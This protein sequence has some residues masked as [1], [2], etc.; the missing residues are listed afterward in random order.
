MHKTVLW[1][2]F[3]ATT[4]G[5]YAADLPS[6]APTAAQTAT[7]T[8]PEAEVQADAKNP[9]EAALVSRP[10][11]ARK[12]LLVGDSTTQVL[13]GWGGS[14]CA[15]HVSAFLAC[16]DLARGGR[17]TR[18]FRVEGSWDMAMKEMTV[19]GY[20][21]VYVLIQ[22]GHNDQHGRPGRSTDL[23]T[24]FPGNLRRYVEDARS[25]GAVPVLVTP[26]VR[27][28]FKDGK[29]NND[30]ADWSDAVRKVAADLKVPLV[31]LNA[32]SAEAV[33]AMGAAVATRLAPQAPSAAI[34]TAAE[35]G[36]TIGLGKSA[37]P[38]QPVVLPESGPE[39]APL[40]PL[41]NAALVFDYTHL[42]RAG[43]DYFSAIVAA[44]L[45]RAV[46]ELRWDLM[47]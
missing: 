1:A 44:E 23:A 26:L 33:Q 45:A 22:F 20:E 43:A 17:S 24:T 40:V 7:T 11:K 41:G 32:R 14:F 10:I 38:A 16:I 27:R 46:P 4:L 47:P 31:D 21:K 2:A 39:N 19:A 18:S 36:T 29:L 34:L 35:K 6:V 12:I 3:L 8:P 42:G 28:T 15:Y 5:A 13:S 9:A 37:V 25:V 30:L